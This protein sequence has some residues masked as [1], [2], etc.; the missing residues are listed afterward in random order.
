MI[1]TRS[2]MADLL[3]A[4]RTRRWRVKRPGFH[5]GSGVPWVRRSRLTGFHAAVV[6]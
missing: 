4:I 1:L 6:G 3:Y 5:G 2:D